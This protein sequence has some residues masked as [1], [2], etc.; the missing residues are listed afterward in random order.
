MAP[1]T[2]QDNFLFIIKALFL[3]PD[4]PAEDLRDMT[5]PGCVVE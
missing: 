4:D 2:G 5:N 1:D 3:L